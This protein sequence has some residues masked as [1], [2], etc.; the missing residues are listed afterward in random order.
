MRSGKLFLVLSMIL[1]ASYAS[2][3]GSVNTNMIWLEPLLQFEFVQVYTPEGYD[4]EDTATRYPVIYY[5]HGFGQSYQSTPELIDVLDEMIGSDMIEPVIVVKVD[6]NCS[7]YGQCSWY[8]DSELNGPI[9]QYIVQIL[10]DYI[11]ERYNTLAEPGKR[12]L[13]GITM[14]GY[15]AVRLAMEYPSS[16]GAA[17]SHNGVLD[18]RSYLMTIMQ[19]VIREHGGYGPFYPSAGDYSTM[20]FSSAGAWSPNLD[21]S[22]E[23]VDLP[24]YPSGETNET[25]FQRWQE[26]NPTCL[27]GNATSGQ[28]PAIYADCS[29]ENYWLPVNEAFRD[30][31]LEYGLP[32][33]MEFYDRE[34]TDYSARFRESLTF[35]NSHFALAS[36]VGDGMQYQPATFE[37][38]PAY[39]NPFN[40]TTTIRITLPMTTSLQLDV[41]NVMGQRVGI[42][43]DGLVTGGEQRYTLDANGL[44]SGIYIIRAEAEGLGSIM[45][46]IF[47]VR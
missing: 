42:L 9:E 3:Q 18:L 38:A 27:I 20:L 30:S 22:P 4:Q 2:G 13:L 6:A 7:Q 34:G 45:Q 17:A 23:Q 16:F 36:D 46:R 12:A 35:L 47:L 37:M 24:V 19:D 26:N 28:C 21:A 25:V 8:T 43:S 33:T 14:G 29:Q 41:V 5:L 32:V 11:D 15:G 1:F 31:C 44:A 39:P 10:V 40:S